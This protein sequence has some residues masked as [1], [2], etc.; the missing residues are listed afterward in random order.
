M[1]PL[2]HYLKIWDRLS[3]DRVDHFIANSGFVAQRIRKFYRRKAEIIH[4]PVNIDEFQVVDVKSDYYLVLGQ[5]TPYKRADLVVDAFLSNG[6]KLVIIGDG[7]QYRELKNKENSNIQVLGRM[8]WEDCK[9]YLQE[10]KALVFPGVEDFGMVPVEAMACG[11]PVLAYAKGGAL[12]TVIDGYSGFLFYEQTI[13]SLN[14]CILKFET[15]EGQLNTV[16]IRSQAEK[17]SREIFKSEISA[18]IIQRLTA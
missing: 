4:P 7:E 12:E 3:A 14:D 18:Y 6:K 5:L 10:A 17:F 2:I 16:D 9:R 13:E 11:T 8:P 1:Y 15:T